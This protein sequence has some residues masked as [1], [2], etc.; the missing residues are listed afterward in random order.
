MAA[1]EVTNDSEDPLEPQEEEENVKNDAIAS[2]PLQAEGATAYHPEFMFCGECTSCNVHPPE[3]FSPTDIRHMGAILHSDEKGPVRTK[4]IVDNLTCPSQVL[5]IQ[6]LLQPLPGISKVI[7]NLEEK[8]VFV[9]HDAASTPDRLVETLKEMGYTARLENEDSLDPAVGDLVRSQL[10]VQG[11]CCASE[12]PSIKKI[13]KPLAGVSKLQINITTKMVY[14]HHNPQVI[15]V[16]EISMQL[17]SQ[18]FEARVIKDGAAR[19]PISA[20]VGRT[21]LHADK[22]LVQR[23]ISPIQ[24]RLLPIKGVK[25]VGINVA[26]SVVYIEHDV[27]VVSAQEISEKLQNTCPNVVATNAQEEIVQRAATAMSVAPSKY[28][29]STLSVTNLSLNHI[30]L[31][32]KTLHQN[33]I[34][35]QL[36][37][38]Y[39]HV[40]SKTLKLEHDPR[41]LQVDSVVTLLR[42]VGLDA[43]VIVDGAV[44]HLALPLMEDYDAPMYGGMDKDMQPYLHINVILSGFFW[45]LSILSYIGGNWC[46]LYLWIV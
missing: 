34:R 26:E 11:I 5:V 17:F 32:E 29:A 7:V 13:V 21:T 27:S 6:S 40:P 46:V 15:D 2:M 24:Q 33:Y 25:R 16:N 8:L 43:S 41:L 30:K 28:V 45:F 42:R 22:V 9:D 39:P 23:D 19:K 1:P 38:F 10:Y 18:G 4:L 20:S 36:R 44:E 12:C 14:V 37:A 35:A 31:L 3:E